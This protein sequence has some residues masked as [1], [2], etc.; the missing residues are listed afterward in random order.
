MIYLPSGEQVGRVTSG[1]FSPT[2]NQGIGLGFVDARH[3][4]VGTAVTFG[5]ERLRQAAALSPR[6]FFKAGS[7]KA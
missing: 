6:N 3:A 4:A 7:L 5:D 1:T 2:L